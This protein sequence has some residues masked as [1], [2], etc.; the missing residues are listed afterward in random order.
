MTKTSPFMTG[1]RAV[2]TL[3]F[4]YFGLRKLG[5][6][7][8]D[9]A[10]YEAIGF[11]QF[12]RYITGSIEVIGASLLWVRDWE[13]PA[14]LLLLGTMIVGLSA[15]LI[16]VGPPYWHMLMLMVGT[17]TVAYVYRDQIVGLIR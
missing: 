2:L 8:T 7:S 15:L 3:A 6:F 16:W 12:P 11:G 17:T 14:G 9:V 5:S 1:L 10:I 13:G 4:L